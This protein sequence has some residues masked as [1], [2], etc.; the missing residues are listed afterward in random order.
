MEIRKMENSIKDKEAEIAKLSTQIQNLQ[1]E[2]TTLTKEKAASEAQAAK[3]VKE[4]TDSLAKAQKEKD[5]ADAKAAR[6]RDTIKK[7]YETKISNM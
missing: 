3:A 1:Q 7:Q 4:K 6:E 2:K 5:E